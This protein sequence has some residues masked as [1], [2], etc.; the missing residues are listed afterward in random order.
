VKLI[1]L[2][3][4]VLVLLALGLVIVAGAVYFWL[5]PMA[6]RYLASL[7]AILQQ[8]PAA[9]EEILPALPM[10]EL[11]I[12]LGDLLAAVPIIEKLGIEGLTQIQEL[13]SGG[14]T[15][16]EAQQVLAILQEKL[17]AAELAQL[18][19]L[20]PELPKMQ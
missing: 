13:A 16:E 8:S 5:W 7:S 19:E 4:S 12:G 10:E 3:A 15:A 14:F 2:F 1:K 6:Q 20:L 17:S 11:G 9:V 18:K